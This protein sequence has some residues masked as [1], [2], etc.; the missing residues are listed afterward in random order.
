MRILKLKLHMNMTSH[1]F[2]IHFEPFISVLVSLPPPRSPLFSLRAKG[3][4]I[5]WCIMWNASAR[6]CTMHLFCYSSRH[7]LTQG[8]PLMQKWPQLL[9]SHLFIV[10]HWTPICTV[11]HKT[12]TGLI[13]TTTSRFP[14][15]SFW[16]PSMIISCWMIL[17]TFSASL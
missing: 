7:S 17:C 13:A 9:C 11:F 2:R 5:K 12:Q 1:G 4:V 8:K 16:Q 14:E 10:M 6:L 3:S 15:A